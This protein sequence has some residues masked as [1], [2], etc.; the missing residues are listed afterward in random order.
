M[1]A[2]QLSNLEHI[3]F[4]APLYP[5]PMKLL[6]LMLTSEYLFADLLVYT[7]VCYIKCLDIQKLLYYVHFN[8]CNVVY[9]S[10]QQSVYE[11]FLP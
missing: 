11:F 7:T 3:S 1:H 2:C 5:H 10:K 8:G 6:E 4:V 9:T